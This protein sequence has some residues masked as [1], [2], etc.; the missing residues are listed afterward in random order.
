MIRFGRYQLDATQGL[1]RGTQEVHLTPKSLGV[2]CHLAERPGRVVTKG[3]LFAAVWSDAA[4]TDSALATC[5]QEIRRALDD[6]ARAPRFVETV[7]RRGYRFAARTSTAEDGAPPEVAI[8]AH[9]DGPLI[10]RESEVAAVLAAFDDA[11]RSARRMCF[12]TG[13]PGVGKSA[14]FRECV[15][16]IAETGAVTTWAQCVEHSGRG[17]PYQPLLDALMRLC[18]RSA[19]EQTIALLERHA[20]MWLAQLPGLLPPRHSARLMRVV[21]GA[22]RDR[23]LRELTYALEAMTTHEPLLLGIEDVHW[24]DPSTL[25]WLAAVAPRPEPAKLLIVA[26]LR[27]PSAGD[28]ESPLVALRGTLRA[29]QLAQEVTLEGLDEASVAR[30]VTYRLPPSPGR[31]ADFERLSHR[32]RM[33]TGGNPLFLANVL[34]QLIDNSVVRQTPDGWI[35]NGDLETADLGIP[36]S[37]RPVIDRQLASLPAALRRHLE[38]ACVIGESFPIAVV[39]AVD[40]ADVEELASTL[41]VASLRRYLRAVES[42]PSPNGLGWPQLAFAHTLY[43][44][45]LYDGI[46]PAF[47]AD[48][49]RR[50]GGY[51]ERAWGDGAVQMAAELALHFERGGDRERAIH[52]LRFAAETAQR[53][54][55]FREARAH[56]ERALELLD[57]WPDDDTRAAKELPLRMGLGAA[58]MALSGFGAPDVEAS[59]SRARNLSHRVGDAQRFPALFGLWLFYWGRGEIGTADELV[60]ELHGLSDRADASL[61][62]QALHA[63]WATS[64]SQGRLDATVAEARAG[65][66]LYDRDRDAPMAAMFGSHDA[67]VCALMFASRALVLQGRAEEAARMGD[68]AVEM[69]TGL[70]HP[71]SIALALKFRAAVEQA[72]GNPETAGRFAQAAIEVATDLGFGLMLAWCTTIAGWAAVRSGDTSRGL[73]TIARGIDAARGTGSDAFMPYLLGM[74]A[75]ASLAAGRLG[76]G[77]ASAAEALAVARRTGERFYE[78][79]LLRS[80]GEL[81]LA[82]GADRGEAD[83]A[84]RSAVTIA[85]DQGASMLVLRSAI[86]LA[87]ARDV[88]DR[89]AR[90]LLLREALRA[91]PDDARLPEQAEAAL[92]LVE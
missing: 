67:G 41:A 19:G 75:D 25:D 15:A 64:F 72:R 87:R 73:S 48:L 44:D 3:E 88:A 79:E 38:T 62:L 16:R 59:Y 36:A 61:R 11:R 81:L 21:A 58:A 8:L 7:H 91:L 14:V 86:R 70:D 78:A 57:R 10:G 83:E 77:R 84:F 47:R 80:T 68:E 51:L 32:V 37:I 56:Y 89:P 4:V 53:R 13:E 6:D 26:T 39:A 63:S 65:A 42:G 85:R 1:R 66:A 76:H 27:P 5:I 34:D 28:A 20:P 2:L 45:A 31:S 35:A 12:I 23:M 22:S 52:H 24:S 43:R 29:K 54:S 90:L 69:A 30:Y 82:A 49:H 74:E 33:H 60:R 40:G 50:V 71:F 92:L 9:P 46:P 18:R 17:E 55:A